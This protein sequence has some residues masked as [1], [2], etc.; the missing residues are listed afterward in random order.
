MIESI[1]M[2]PTTAT[3]HTGAGARAGPL[4]LESFMKSSQLMSLAVIRSARCTVAVIPMTCRMSGCGSTTPAGSGVAP[5]T[6]GK[7][8]GGADRVTDG[9]ESH[10][11][12][13]S[14]STTA[15]R[16]TARVTSSSDR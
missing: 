1:R 13:A 6:S 8:A 15:H 7:V 11:A 3:A 16:R 14:A 5:T 12:K 10:A 4:L 2:L 9:G